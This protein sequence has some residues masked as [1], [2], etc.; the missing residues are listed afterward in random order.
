[1]SREIGEIREAL[2]DPALYEGADTARLAELGRAEARLAEALASA[3]E[4]W[5]HASAR[6]EALRDEAS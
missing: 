2:A 3:E 5:L 6:L 1:L 4:D